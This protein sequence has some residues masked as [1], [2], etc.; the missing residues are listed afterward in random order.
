MSGDIQSELGAIKE[1]I[2]AIKEIAAG[3]A[4]DRSALFER[5]NRNENNITALREAVKSLRGRLNTICAELQRE[6][7]RDI[8]RTNNK[9]ALVA[10]ALTIA[11]IFITVG[12]SMILK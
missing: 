4:D 10:V 6:K 12:I 1:K 9:I 8:A 7:D 11:E 5:A 2:I 3:L